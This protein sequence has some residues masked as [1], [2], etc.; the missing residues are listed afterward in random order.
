MALAARRSELVALILAD[1][2]FEAKGVR[3]R[4]RLSKTDQEGEGASVAVPDGRRVKPVALL[5]DW[6][7]AAAITE[8]PIFRPLW[9]NN[10]TRQQPLT[11]HAVA[12]IVK[13]RFAAVGLDPAKF[14]V[15]ASGRGS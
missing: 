13:L 6:L 9:R 8:G 15:T 3:V 4:I 12:K 5:K 14:A 11:G 10:T 2:T 1:L 7:A